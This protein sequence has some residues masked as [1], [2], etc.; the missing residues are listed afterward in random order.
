L[1]PTRTPPIL[2]TPAP[3]PVFSIAFWLLAPCGTRPTEW[4]RSVGALLAALGAGAVISHRTA[5]LPPPI[6]CTAFLNTKPSPLKKN[7]TKK[8]IFPQLF[9]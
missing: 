2:P 4:A 9:Y 5:G 3:S 7:K 1:I 6:R 8:N